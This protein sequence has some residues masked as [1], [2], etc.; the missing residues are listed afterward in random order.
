[1]I[2]DKKLTFCTAKAFGSAGTTY[3]DVIDLGVDMD[4]GI[5]RDIEIDMRV[6]EAAVAASTDGNLTLVLQTATDEAF[7]TPIELMRTSAILEAT[8]V[9]GYEPARWRIPSPT[10]RYLRIA[11]IAAT[12]DFTAG[13]LDAAVVVDRQ[14]NRF[15]PAGYSVTSA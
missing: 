7:T 13:K 10:K 9:I 14:A 4:V 2:K 6:V 1:M 12:Q 5:G 3:S 15:Y 11:L 8:L